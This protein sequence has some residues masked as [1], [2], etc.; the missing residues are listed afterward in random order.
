MPQVTKQDWREANRK[1][2]LPEKAAFITLSALIII[3]AIVPG[4]FLVTAP[5]ASALGNVGPAP[6][7]FQ[8]RRMTFVVDNTPYVGATVTTVM[9]YFRNK[10]GNAVTISSAG[11][12]DSPNYDTFYSAVAGNPIVTRYDLF[13]VQTGALLDT[14]N[15]NKNTATCVLN[16]NFP[17]ATGVD[18]RTGYFGAQLRATLTPRAGEVYQNGFW[19]TLSAG[20]VV[21]FDSTSLATTFA[22]QENIVAKRYTDWTLKFGADCTVLPPAGKLVPFIWYDPDNGDPGVQ[23]QKSSFRIIDVTG[24][25]KVVSLVLPGGN[26]FTTGASPASLNSATNRVT[27]GN[28]SKTNGHVFFTALPGHIYQVEWDHV[29][30]NNTLQFQLPFDSIYFMTKGCAIKPYTITPTLSTALN[31]LEPGTAGIVNA[32]ATANM[33]PTAPY[34]M[35]VAASG[36]ASVPAPAYAPAPSWAMGAFAGA[37][38]QTRSFSVTIANTVPDGTTICF[39][40]TINPAKWTQAG[41]FTALTS[42]PLCLP[43]YRTRYPAVE[44]FKGDIHAG[45]GMCVP[46]TNVL[47]GLG[48]PGRVSGNINGGSFGQYVV[49]ASTT[50]NSFGSAGSVGNTALTR[51]NFG[52]AGAYTQV[53]RPNLLLAANDYRN[54]GGTGITTRS[55]ASV[56]LFDVTNQGGIWYFDGGG[57]LSI[58]GTVGASLSIV[59]T[60]P[61]LV[62]IVPS[63]STPTGIVRSAAAYPAHSS[64]GVEGIPS[65]GVITAGDIVIPA[66]V[67]NVDAYLFANGLI[68]TCEE[69]QS[70][71]AATIKLCANTLAVNGFLMANKIAF[72]RLGPPN[73]KGIVPAE[74]VTLSP[75]IYLNPPKFFDSSVDGTFIEGLGEKQPL[76]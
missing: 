33:G 19:V 56:P 38:A 44:G 27:P 45:G 59:K 12:T 32:V 7:D 36:T 71:V 11:L 5:K 6:G 15:A 37:G 24:A 17:A 42:A 9:T 54:N 60:G 65:L 3:A 75:Q 55:V 20:N 28:N 14:C 34:S 49:S 51:L 2:R 13:D 58:T 23:P 22:M 18:I 76:Y 21:G 62:K 63:A 67:R 31:H 8:G 57:D 41:G 16:F 70:A 74:I 35:N 1:L 43:V 30:S 68:D 53:C 52:S 61:G 40:N 64:P 47:A 39:T 50:I 25:A 4:L 29:Y 73:T 46:E 72:R 26:D 66:A 48:S 10:N 69:G